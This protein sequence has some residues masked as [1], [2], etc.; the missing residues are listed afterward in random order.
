MKRVLLASLAALLLAAGCAPM[1]YTKADLDGLIVCDTELMDRIERDAARRF[2]TIQWAN[3][4]RVTL[5]VI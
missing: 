1:Q 2:A 5:R 4:P 3:C